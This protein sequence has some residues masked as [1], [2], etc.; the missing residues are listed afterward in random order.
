MNFELIRNIDPINEDSWQNKVFLT[1]DMDWCSDEVL[2][3]TLNIIE[4][5]N[6]KATFFVTHKTDLLTRMNSNKNI[7]LGIHPNFNPLL[8]GD[9]KYGKNVDEV[10]MYYKQ[11]IPNAK[12][13]R[14][15]SMTQSSL[16]LNSFE[17]FN[18]TYDCNTFIPYSSNIKLK[19]YKHWSNRLIKV[20]YFWEDDIHCL[21]HDPW[22]IQPYL[23]RH[24]LKVFDFH[25]MH[26]FLNTED[27]Q[28]YENS[29][30]D[31]F[32]FTKLQE[33]RNLTF[34]GVENFFL[35]IIHYIKDKNDN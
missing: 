33:K 2:S 11:I 22:N 19:P 6:I 26:I 29:R 24:G 28:R 32:D 27:L 18:L 3:Y 15:H 30:E 12:S 9:F 14:S 17:T 13:V 21:S 7:E 8:S 4:K 20:P 25:P 16:I 35:E 34:Y 10:I 23:R 1:F 31:F 5:Y